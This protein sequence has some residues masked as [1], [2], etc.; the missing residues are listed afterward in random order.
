MKYRKIQ[1]KSLKIS[2]ESYKI[3]QQKFHSEFAKGHATIQYYDLALYMRDKLE[4]LD[5]ISELIYNHNP[6]ISPKLSKSI[7]D[8]YVLIK[9]ILCAC[10]I[11]IGGVSILY[12]EVMS[13][14]LKDLRQSDRLSTSIKTF[15]MTMHMQKSSL[16]KVANAKEKDCNNYLT[17]F[18]YVD[19][20]QLNEVIS[21][22]RKK[23]MDLQNTKEAL[24]QVLLDNKHIFNPAVSEIAARRMSVRVQ[25][26]ATRVSI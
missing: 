10:S 7:I 2:F 21:E 19:L 15:T 26:D 20:K 17:R 24:L 18:F 5:H 12:T 25:L 3:L 9:K 13:N 23:P 16:K 6:D 4:V 22:I 11:E 1:K 8:E 14:I